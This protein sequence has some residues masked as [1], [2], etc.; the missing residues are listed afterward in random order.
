M[1]RAP[2]LVAAAEQRQARQAAAELL[3]SPFVKRGDVRHDHSKEL[4]NVTLLDRQ[5]TIHVRLPGTEG[6]IEQQLQR[7]RALMQTDGHPITVRRVTENVATA[8]P[9]DDRQFA[10]ADESSQ[11]PTE[12]E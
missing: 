2:L 5:T 3:H 8:A 6:W 11:L 4:P 1:A 7:E 10:R 9:V 12:S